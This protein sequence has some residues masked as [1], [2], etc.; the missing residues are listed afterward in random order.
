MTR[1]DGAVVVGP[2]HAMGALA[3]GGTPPVTL[4]VAGGVLVW[5]WADDDLDPDTTLAQAPTAMLDD[6]AAAQDWVWALYGPGVAEVLDTPDGQ[7]VTW[8]PGQDWLPQCAARFAFG[9]W[10]SAWWPASTT[11]GIPALDPQVL[12]AEME[13]LAA[14]LDLLF[15]GDEP[16]LPSATD[17][18]WPVASGYALA[19]G[20]GDVIGPAPVGVTVSTGVCGTRWSDLPAGWV[21]A[22]DRAVSWRLLQDLG[23]WFFQVRAAAGPTTVTDDARLVADTPGRRVELHPDRDSFGRCWIGEAVGTTS[24]PPPVHVRV[25]L[26]GFAAQAGFAGVAADDGAER[27]QASV[28]ALARARLDA[29][30]I[31][32]TPGPAVTGPWRAE[33]TARTDDY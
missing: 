8:D 4:A 23:H 13:P 22:S 3:N 2:E 21:D 18:P 11:D 27:W 24:D 33:R 30:G 1:A 6:V 31:A 15:A 5:A 28:R 25:H 7:T 26:P 10:L 29:A 20:P 19:A 14:R 32:S 17:V 12:R 16:P 9:T